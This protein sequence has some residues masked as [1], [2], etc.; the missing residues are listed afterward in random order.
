MQ[1]ESILG[2]N[3]SV[4]EKSQNRAN[5][6]LDVKELIRKKRKAQKSL[7]RVC[8][9]ENKRNVNMLCNVLRELMK[10]V[11]NESVQTFL[12]GNGKDYS[13]WKATKGLKIQLSPLRQENG[14]W[15]RKMNQK[16]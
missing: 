1:S 8:T 6:T 4:L 2:K 15:A 9:P 16:K 12:V 3:P 5:Y 7:Q 11:K 14:T 13:L 10:K